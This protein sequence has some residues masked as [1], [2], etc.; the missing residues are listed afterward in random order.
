MNVKTLFPNK[1]LQ[2]ADLQGKPATV[3]MT[4]VT[5]EKLRPSAAA[6]EEEKPVLHFAH[7][8][9]ALVLNRTIA[10][11]IAALYGEETD[12]WI[13]NRITL[14]PVPM[15]VARKHVIAIRV[16]P[17]AAKAE[18]VTEP[19][20]EPPA[21][22]PAPPIVTY[23]NGQP[24]DQTNAKELDAYAAYCAAMRIFPANADNLR[25]WCRATGYKPSA[26]TAAN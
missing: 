2:G 8:D 5:L 18:P 10:N 7:T 22:K 19:A 4:A 15:E 21:A 9:K 16:K 24:V 12:G 14:I 6:P 23:G 26:S 20:P 13:G 3:T 25:S 17:P 11:Q 1:Y